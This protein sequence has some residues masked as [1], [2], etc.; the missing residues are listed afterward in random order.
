MVD[1]LGMFRRRP[2]K[3]GAAGFARS[4]ED[5][6]ALGDSFG[7]MLASPVR[8]AP[9]MARSA[10]LPGLELPEP[11]GDA[12]PPRQPRPR[13][14]GPRPNPNPNPRANGG[15]APQLIKRPGFLAVHSVEKS[16]GTRQV[17]R[18]VSIY[19]RRGEAVGLLGP[20]GAGK[21]TVFYMITGL[22]KAD[23]GAIEL[24]GHDVTRLPMYQRARLGIGYLPQ[25]ASI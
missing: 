3:R 13:T 19:V 6:T 2:A 7:D 11:Q 25:E 21:T 24:D 18:G 8:D 12:E 9:P 5:I 22:I 14:Q 17:V 10:A 20:N 4:R 16:F 23:R 15:G 1:F